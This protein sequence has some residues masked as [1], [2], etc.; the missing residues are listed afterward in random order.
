M[1]VQVASHQQKRR[2]WQSF[3]ADDEAVGC[4]RIEWV[5]C[6]IGFRV[7]EGHLKRV[8]FRRFVTYSIGWCGRGIEHFWFALNRICL[9]RHRRISQPSIYCNTSHSTSFKCSFLRSG[10]DSPLT[11]ISFCYLLLNYGSRPLEC[12]QLASKGVFQ[13]QVELTQSDP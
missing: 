9:A 2:L 1:T 10:F 8:H 11:A 3:S 4:C 12:S 13:W 7:A 5:G 6:T